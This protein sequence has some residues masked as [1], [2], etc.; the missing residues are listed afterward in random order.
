MS[1]EQAEKIIIAL[2]GMISEFK[3]LN[4]KLDSVIEKQKKVGGNYDCGIRTFSHCDGSL[5]IERIN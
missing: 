1:E 3:K 5:E 2:S 4:K